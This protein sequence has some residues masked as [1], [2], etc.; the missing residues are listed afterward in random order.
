[1]IESDFPPNVNFC[2]SRSLEEF[3]GYGT[4]LSSFINIFSKLINNSWKIST[5]AQENPFRCVL[6]NY[7]IMQFSIILVSKG[8]DDVTI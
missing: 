8:R 4:T 5:R 7:G 1:M 3:N 2:F 6:N